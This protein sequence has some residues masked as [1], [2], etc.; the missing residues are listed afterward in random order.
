ME[1]PLLYPRDL[2]AKRVVF[3]PADHAQIALCRG[4]HNRLGLAYR[5]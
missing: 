2:I 4:E 3:T 5:P 1:A